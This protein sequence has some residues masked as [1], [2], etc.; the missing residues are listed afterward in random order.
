MHEVVRDAGFL[1]GGG[2]IDTAKELDEVA[3]GAIGAVYES[4]DAD[5]QGEKWDQREEDLICDRPGEEG[6]IVVREV[7]DD[8][9]AAR[10]GAG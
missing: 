6:T 5:E 2:G 8:R 10:D 4:E 3:L 1:R 7:R 9:S